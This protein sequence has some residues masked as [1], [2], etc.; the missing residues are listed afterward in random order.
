MF[1]ILP[2]NC[3]PIGYNKRKIILVVFYC[4]F[5]YF[6][7]RKRKCSIYNVFRW[8]ILDNSSDTSIYK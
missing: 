2:N 4:L 6:M 7:Q 8:V 5:N 3:T 1:I